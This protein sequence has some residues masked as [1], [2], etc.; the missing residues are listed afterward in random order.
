M[1]Y[2]GQTGSSGR[3]KTLMILRYLPKN[4]EANI[5]GVHLAYSYSQTYLS[6]EVK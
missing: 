2:E 6:K 5:A 4:I 3:K 1:K